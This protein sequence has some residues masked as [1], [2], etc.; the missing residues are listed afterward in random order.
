MTRILVIGRSGQV[1]MALAELGRKDQGLTVTTLGRPEIDLALPALVR[2]AIAVRRPDVVVNAAAFTAVDRAEAEETLAMRINCDG[3]AAAAAAADAIGA[4]FVQLSTDYVFSGD[5]DGPYV[6]DDSPAPLGAYG[7]S[8]LAGEQAVRAANPQALILRASWIFSPF[9]HNFVR[10]MLRLGGDRDVVRVVDD[11]AGNPTSALDLAA[12][13][14]RLAPVIGAA[15][16]DGAILHL[17]G[18]GA[19]TWCGLAREVFRASAARGGPAP[20]VE[21]IATADYPTAA[22][23]PANSRLDC[24]AF[25]QRF[26]FALGPWQEAVAATVARLLST[27]A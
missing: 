12:A 23:R 18:S 15:P 25:R 14:L 22:R 17:C 6:E 7:R 19:T 16:G 20:E 5:K 4:S 3:A 21:A 13:I 11:Q 24:S 9:G 27:T 1:A 2:Q 26:G 8:K 10:T